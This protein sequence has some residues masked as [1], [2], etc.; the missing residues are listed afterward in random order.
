MLEPKTVRFFLYN[1]DK[2]KDDIIDLEET[3]KSLK[4]C[5]VTIHIPCI[6]DADGSQFMGAQG[7]QT[8][9]EAI[10][11]AERWL[12]YKKELSFKRRMLRAINCVIH[13]LPDECT[14]WHIIRMRY[15]KRVSWAVIAHKLNYD[16]GYL[17][18]RDFKIIYE[19]IG[20]FRARKQ[21]PQRFETSKKEVTN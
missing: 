6:A 9:N 8:E 5:D 21:Q 3:L 17:K 4:L 13:F 2:L 12:K 1:F 20:N 15:F 18:N 14:D 11:N 10:R 16:E 19:I 7:S